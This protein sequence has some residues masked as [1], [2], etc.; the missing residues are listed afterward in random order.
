[1][2]LGTKHQ[3]ILVFLTAILSG[4]ASTAGVYLIAPYQTE[5]I[6][7]QMEYER[8]VSTYEKFLDE[9]ISEPSSL[10]FK[11]ISLDQMASNITTDG[12]IRSVEDKLFEISRSTEYD[13]LFYSLTRH[14]K[15]L[16]LHGS[17]RVR[18]YCEDITSV[19]L[20]NRYAVDWTYH[21]Q[22]MVAVRN[23]WDDNDGVVIGWEP[24]VTDEE[25]ARFLI[26]SAQY[27]ELIQQLKS[28]ISTTDA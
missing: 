12:S 2:N 11:V 15:L 4:V 9:S 7:R 22:E 26:L 1:M 23:Q 28:E 6:I 19:L 16:E 27:N 24:R 5:Q 25:R 3:Y 14:F 8:K 13:K 20:G 18:K 10:V 17:E 21:T